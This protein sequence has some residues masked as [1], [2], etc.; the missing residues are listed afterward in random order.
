MRTTSTPAKTACCHHTPS[1][2]SNVSV[3]FGSGRLHGGEDRV[4]M[5]TPQA[6]QRKGP[7]WWL[8]PRPEARCE[9]LR[10]LPLRIDH[11]IERR[12]SASGAPSPLGQPKMKRAS[13]NDRNLGER[14][15][16]FRWSS[17]VSVGRPLGAVPTTGGNAVE[18]GQG[19]ARVL[20]PEAIGER[21]LH[22]GCWLEAKSLPA[23]FLLRSPIN[24]SA[25]FPNARPSISRS[26]SPSPAISA[27]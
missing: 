18:A 1:S 22:I 9:R 15:R 26:L 3:A 5:G 19:L 23:F 25:S 8:A 17:L 16:N 13:S 6:E 12:S 14:D 2:P 7:G 11:V 20:G 10:R 27:D 24:T 21:L 4:L